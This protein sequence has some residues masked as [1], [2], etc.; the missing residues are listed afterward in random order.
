MLKMLGGIF[1]SADHIV[2]QILAQWPKSD[3]GSTPRYL[4]GDIFNENRGG[5][6]VN[7]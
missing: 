7:A 5:L 1:V 2:V 4:A 3:H 6:Q